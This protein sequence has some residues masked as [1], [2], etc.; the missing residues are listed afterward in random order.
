M[1]NTPTMANIS[2]R[3]RERHHQPRAESLPGCSLACDIVER[4]QRSN[5][6]ELL[7]VHAAIAARTDDAS[8][9]AGPVLGRASRKMS[10]NG[11][12]CEGDVELDGL[13]GLV[14]SSFHLTSDAHDLSNLNQARP[15]RANRN[16]SADDRSPMKVPPDE[17]L[18]DNRTPACRGGSIG[19]SECSALNH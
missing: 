9:E 14:R 10:S 17:C 15:R 11:S 12:C 2:A 8:A 18:V 16:P 13:L 7:L 4:D 1:P 19:L 6:H 5:G 3:H